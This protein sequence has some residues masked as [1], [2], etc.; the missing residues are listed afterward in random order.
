MQARAREQGVRTRWVGAYLLW[1]GSKTL[2]SELELLS[3]LFSNNFLRCRSRSS[4]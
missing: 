2:I 1:N 4:L 3:E